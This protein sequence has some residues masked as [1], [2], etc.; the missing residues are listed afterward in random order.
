MQK[1]CGSSFLRFISFLSMIM[2]LATSL[3]ACGTSS[4]QGQQSAKNL[5][6]STSAPTNPATKAL[7]SASQQN[8]A[9]ILRYWTRE[10]MASATSIDMVS[11]SLTQFK[12]TAANV[13]RA[14]PQLSS[15]QLPSGKLPD[16]PAMK[17]Q[18]LQELLKQFAELRGEN[19][20]NPFSLSTSL[21]NSL[22]QFN[23][24]KP[25]IA[26][27]YPLSTVGKIF[28][29]DGSRNFVCSGAAISS[30]SKSLVNTAGHCVYDNGHWMSNWIFCPMYYNG[31][32]PYGCWAANYLYTD[33]NW[34]R[35]ATINSAG[36]FHG[37]FAYDYGVAVMH[38][39]QRFGRLV[40]RVGGLGYIYRAS[41]TQTFNSY[42]Y[43][44]ATPY[45]GESMK[46][47]S[48]SDKVWDEGSH[49]Y[50]LSIVCNMTAGSSGGPW[51]IKHGGGWYL[52]GHNS[53]KPYSNPNAMYSPYYDNKWY[54][55][56]MSAAGASPGEAV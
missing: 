23:A 19:I 29:S 30:A 49:T 33:G 42:G 50:M 32:A 1:Q 22:P 2:L 17:P 20:T 5:P 7:Q 8:A 38:P 21:L 41:A 25:T 6:T 12:Q 55:V 28:F 48:G 9:S 14:N 40:D 43:P 3:S 45:H 37:D 18:D 54:S 10:K 46:S 52:N 53:F 36:E 34:A 26:Y 44:A 47:C 56:Y 51:I 27:S 31:R 4:N 35:S 24:S 16:I 11:R 15:V 13:I 39:S